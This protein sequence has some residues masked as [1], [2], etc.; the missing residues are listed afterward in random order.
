MPAQHLRT[1]PT[2]ELLAGGHRK[3]RY[4]QKEHIIRLAVP[5][6]AV[7]RVA[8]GGTAIDPEVVGTV[9]DPS[10]RADRRVPW[11]RRCEASC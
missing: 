10:S 8:A 11:N 2:V 1:R 6:D 4:M 5:V 9:G 7:G 3:G